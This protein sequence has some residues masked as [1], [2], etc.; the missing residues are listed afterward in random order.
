M[1]ANFRTAVV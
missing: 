1:A